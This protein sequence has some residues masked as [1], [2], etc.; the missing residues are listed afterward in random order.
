TTSGR[1]KAPVYD[2]RDSPPREGSSWPLVLAIGCGFILVLGVGFGALAMFGFLFFRMDARP[3]GAV[4]APVAVQVD[5]VAGE[6]VVEQ[7]EPKAAGVQTTKAATPAGLKGEWPQWRGPDR[8][9]VSKETGLLTSWPKEGPKLLWTYES[10]GVG[11]SGP[12]IVGN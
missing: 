6:D 11:F 9:D 5:E 8:S 4:P 2:D 12:A 7:A 10:A 3:P 1:G